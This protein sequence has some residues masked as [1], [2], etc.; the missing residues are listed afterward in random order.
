[1]RVSYSWNDLRQR[2]WLRG[3]E[4]RSV[5]EHSVTSTRFRAR[6]KDGRA[7]H[8]GFSGTDSYDIRKVA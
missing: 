1:M 4:Y 3:H 8:I 5:D 2:W 7:F 6:L